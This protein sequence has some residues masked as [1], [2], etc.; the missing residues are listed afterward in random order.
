M[1]VEI[2]LQSDFWASSPTMTVSCN[3]TEI[4][5][6]ADFVSGEN[7]KITFNIDAQD[8]PQVL[9]LFRENKSVRETII[10]D[11]KIVKDS[12][13]RI[14]DIIIDGI[15]L[16]PLLDKGEFWPIYPEPW[17]SQ[18]KQ[19]G[20]VPPTSHKYCRTIYHNGEWKL[21][22]ESPIHVWFFQNINVEI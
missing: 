16:E 22:F 13:V 21:Q 10:E 3:G 2:I 4:T 9:S 7:K 6:T 12:I 17:Y 20:D 11:G 19:K 5:K 18:Q 14:I 8:G 1:K 15:S